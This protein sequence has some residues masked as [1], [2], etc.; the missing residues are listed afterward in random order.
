MAYF[1]VR[2]A[3]DQGNVKSEFSTMCAC[4]M[5]L[6]AILVSSAFTLSPQAGHPENRSN[7]ERQNLKQSQVLPI[8]KDCISSSAPRMVSS[9]G[10]HPGGSTA[11]V[12]R[13]LSISRPGMVGSSPI[14][15]NHYAP[16]PEICQAPVVKSR[17]ENLR[18]LMRGELAR[19]VAERFALTLKNQRPSRLWW[20]QLGPRYRPAEGTQAF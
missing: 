4:R 19:Q 15:T 7:D 1:V 16:A 5:D 10:V 3:G 9:D 20:S 12:N 11:L 18:V 2:G 8:P 17:V 6:I 13:V 14:V